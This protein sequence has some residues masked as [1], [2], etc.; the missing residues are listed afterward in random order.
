MGIFFKQHGFSPAQTG[1]LTGIRPLI[2]YIS[3]PLILQFAERQ[4]KT[5]ILLIASCLSWILFTFPLG[6]LMPEPVACLYKVN[7]SQVELRNPEMGQ[8]FVYGGRA[9]R[10]ADRNVDIL[11]DVLL[12][13]NGNA[14]NYHGNSKNFDAEGQHLDGNQGNDVNSQV[15]EANAYEQ[16]SDDD[17]ITTEDTEQQPKKVLRRTKRY[18]RF[19]IPG[20]SPQPVDNAKGYDKTKAKNW[21]NPV[22]STMVFEKDSVAKVKNIE[23]CFSL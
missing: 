21:V 10:E 13:N 6:S 3:A 12:D 15:I 22:S 11:D 23:N 8:G 18:I 9:R 4:R 5:R 16:Q 7:D 19:V 2:E 1:I 14:I 20:K 17:L